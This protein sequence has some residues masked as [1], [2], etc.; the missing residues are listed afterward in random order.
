MVLSLLWCYLLDYLQYKTES[1]VHGGQAPGSDSAVTAIKRVVIVTGAGGGL[2]RAYA[3]DLAS[4][5]LRVV[6][7]NRRREVDSAGLGS[8][9]LVVGEIHAAGGEAV[10]SE[11]DVL[12]SGSGQAMLAQALTAWGRVDALVAN[13][14]ID[15]HLAFHKISVEAFRAIFDVNFYGTLYAVHACYA[16]M[17][18]AGWGR[19]V[20]STSSAGLHGL[21]GLSAYSASKSALI[22]L[23]RSVAAEGRSHDVLCNA[24]APY[25]ATRMT[26]QHDN[27]EFIAAMRPEYV[28]P[29]V[30]FLISDACRVSG[31]TIIAG[32]G[33]FRRA[34][35]VEGSGVHF[36]EPARVT[37]EAIEMQ[38]ERI[39]SMAAATEFPDA[40]AAF[41]HFMQQQAQ[42]TL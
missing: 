22:G 7:N 28:A 40:L 16:H 36:A 3:L 27:A 8:A 32:G 25:A 39:G 9:Q 5:G 26:A 15:Q 18:A 19:I 31:Q 12:D 20:V 2:G 6:V 17:R 14:G 35:M 42:A 24:V 23:M 34:A 11:V 37:L 4:R 33:G 1:K 13:A 21:H 41:K 29:L 30:A 10:A 38:M